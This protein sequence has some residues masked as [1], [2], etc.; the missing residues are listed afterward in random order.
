MNDN[1]ATVREKGV[2]GWLITAIIGLMFG[3]T[4]AYADQPSDTATVSAEFETVLEGQPDPARLQA[5]LQFAEAKSSSSGGGSAPVASGGNVWFAI[6]RTTDNRQRWVR[7]TTLEGFLGSV[8][9]AWGDG[10]HLKRV[11]YADGRWVGIFVDTKVGCAE[12]NGFETAGSRQAFLEAVKQRWVD[13]YTLVD[14]AY[15]E[16][17]WFGNFCED[18]RDNTYVTASDW[19]SLSNLISKKWD[20]DSQWHVIS[21]D[22]GPEGWLAVFVKGECPGRNGWTIYESQASLEEALRDSNNDGFAVRNM[23]YTNGN[24]VAMRCE[25]D[26]SNVYESAASWSD[27][28]EII[29]RR[30]GQGLD[31]IAIDYG[32]R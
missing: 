6:F 27:L 1:H 7:D 12:R 2:A 29:K 8:R 28:K 20:Q 16:G 32:R 22:R 31:L 4:A 30:W 23:A 26:I 19:D 15:G 9:K 13:G 25:E 21:A 11:N 24:W 5:M 3:S 10:Y 17:T 14:A 18:P